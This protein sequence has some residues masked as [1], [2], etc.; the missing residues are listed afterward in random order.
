LLPADFGLKAFLPLTP[1][2]HH[3]KRRARSSEVAAVWARARYWRHSGGVLL[4]LRLLIRSKTST[5]RAACWFLFQLHHE[6]VEDERNSSS[7]RCRARGQVE[8]VSMQDAKT[9]QLYAADCRRM[10]STMNVNDGKI[11]LNMADAWD[12]RAKEAERLQETRADK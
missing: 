7:R 12:E 2:L 5:K 9:Y 1:R 4:R 11:L 10:A 3:L 6:T 8:E